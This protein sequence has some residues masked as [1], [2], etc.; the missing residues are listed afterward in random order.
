MDALTDAL[1]ASNLAGVVAYGRAVL[2]HY[3]AED[4]SV[5]AVVFAVKADAF[6]WELQ[7]ENDIAIGGFGL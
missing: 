5:V 1:Q 6:E 3:H 4:S 7:G 2:A